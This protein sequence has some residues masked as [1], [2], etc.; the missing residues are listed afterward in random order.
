MTKSE[1]LAILDATIKKLGKD[2]YIG[3]WLRNVYPEVER[4]MRCDLEPQHDL[5]YYRVIAGGILSAAREEAD[6]IRKQA[7]EYKAKTE[8]EARKMVDNAKHYAAH[9]LR[10]ALEEVA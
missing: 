5:S 10:K 9:H 1:E 3:P 4:D 8:Q 6:R 7:D 2:S